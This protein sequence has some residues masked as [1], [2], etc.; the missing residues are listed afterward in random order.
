MPYL[1][2]EQYRSSIYIDF[3][4]EGP[5][6]QGPPP[7]PHMCGSFKPNPTGKNGKYSA[8]FFKEL[9]KPAKNG[10]YRTAEI[11]NFC[12][13]FES[14]CDDASNNNSFIVYWSIHEETVL[15][16]YLSQTLFSKIEKYLYNLHP[17]ARRYA[18]RTKKFGR[19]QTARGKSLEDFYEAMYRKRKPQPPIKPGPAKVCRQI[20]RACKNKKKWKSFT[21]R[22][23]QYV[24]DLINYNQGDCRST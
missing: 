12:D 8:V 1:N 11:C 10:V 16:K 6:G 21:D 24:N 13:Y 9:W 2:P 20:D 23:K 5:I 22:Q 15:K 7:M 17:I 3:E 19:N 18:R 4:G 14:L